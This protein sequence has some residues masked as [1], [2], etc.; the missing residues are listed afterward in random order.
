M[1]SKARHTSSCQ[2]ANHTLTRTTPSNPLRPHD[3]SHP[4][5]APLAQDE[6]LIFKVFD[7]SS[8]GPRF[9][10]HTAF[11]DPST[12]PASPP[13]SSIEARAVA[14][15]DEAAEVTELLKRDSRDSCH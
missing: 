3:P 1:L 14:F 10:F 8:E 15:F 5:A 13:R 7:A 12:T 6:C 4:S 9:I 11:D 2:T